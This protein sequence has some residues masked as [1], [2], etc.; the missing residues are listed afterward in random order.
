LST[1]RFNYQK[2]ITIMDQKKRE[3]KPKR[4]SNIGT[5]MTIITASTAWAKV[6]VELV[7]L[8]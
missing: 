7:R 8:R 4:R 2:D 6:I 1:R 3:E 5:F